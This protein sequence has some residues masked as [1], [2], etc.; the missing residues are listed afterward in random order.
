MIAQTGKQR[1]TR[2]PHARTSVETRAAIL[3]A[4]ERIFAEAGLEGART[5]AIAAA[6]G[7]NKAMLY[8]YFRSKAGLYSAVLEANAGEF[9][10]RAD[11][12]LSGNGSAG[13]I[14]LRYVGKHLDFVGARPSYA[15]LIQRLMMEG[16]RALDQVIREHSIPVYERLARL[17][18]KG[19]RSGEFRRMNVRHTLVSLNALT[20]FYFTTAPIVR[21]IAGVDVFTK[22]EQARRKKE[23]LRFIRYALFAHPEAIE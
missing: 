14:L 17:V 7:V 20:V 12:V 4:A 19:M 16:D 8:Y 3:R 1:T 18:E 10:R 15:R 23:V 21:R 6:A 13:A 22:A 9:H 2:P 5:D 11:Q